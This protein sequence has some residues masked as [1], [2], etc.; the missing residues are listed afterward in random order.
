[1]NLSRLKPDRTF[2]RNKIAQQLFFMFVLCALVPLSAMTGFLYFQVSGQFSRVVDRRLHDACKDI[3]MN[4]AE[5]L[6]MLESDLNFLT[7]SFL[8]NNSRILW[9][10]TAEVRDHL[11][12]RYRGI[13][14][15]SVSGQRISGLG[16]PL[17]SVQYTPEELRHM[18][19]G[20]A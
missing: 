10:A 14:L 3:G 19:K 11:F 5:R 6:S 1:M 9:S 17:E 20:K 2:L 8:E 12:A 18:A 7:A 15:R 16:A 4:L 13:L